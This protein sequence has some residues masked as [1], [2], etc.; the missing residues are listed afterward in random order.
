MG[1]GNL[2]RGEMYLS[3]QSLTALHLENIYD[4][5]KKPSQKYNIL[6]CFLFF[7]ITI[8]L[9]TSLKN[10]SVVVVLALVNSDLRVPIE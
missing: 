9:I 8:L 4:E 1:K 6:S 7:Y 2:K 10:W 5:K 3:L